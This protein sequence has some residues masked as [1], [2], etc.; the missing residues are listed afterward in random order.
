MAFDAFIQIPNVDGESKRKGFEKQIEIDSFS[1]GASNPSTIGSGGG[2]GAGKAS[3]SSFNIMK[4]T[5]L[6]SV[7]LFQKCCE[8]EHFDKVTVTLNKAGGKVAVDFLKYEFEH[9]FVD[10]IQWSGSS[11]GDDTPTESVSLSFG[12]VVM[13]YTAQGDDASKGATKVGQWD[14]EKVSA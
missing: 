1:L 8:G 12:K 11:G 3:I 2:G 10:S 6:A 9:V 4:K 14:L 5:D 13:T 7:L